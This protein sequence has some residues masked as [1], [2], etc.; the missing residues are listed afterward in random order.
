M[1]TG[2]RDGSVCLR[3]D[4]TLEEIAVQIRG[5]GG[6]MCAATNGER[7]T[8]AAVAFL[9]RPVGALRGKRNQGIRLN[10]RTVGQNL[11]VGIFFYLLVRISDSSSEASWMS[12]QA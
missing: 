1:F 10:S 12:S 6:G 4:G 11:P 5:R 7:G 3:I 8:P 2:G 9:S